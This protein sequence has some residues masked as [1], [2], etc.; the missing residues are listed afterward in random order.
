[1]KGLSGS[2][3]GA[4]ATDLFGSLHLHGSQGDEAHRKM[5]DG[6]LVLDGAEFVVGSLLDFAVAESGEV[7]LDHDAA[8]INV[9][10]GDG[11]AGDTSPSVI[12]DVKIFGAA[13]GP[14]VGVAG[15][16]DGTTVGIVLRECGVDLEGASELEAI[17]LALTPCAGGCHLESGVADGTTVGSED[18]GF[19][20]IAGVNG[21]KGAALHL[22]DDE[23]VEV[24]HIIGG[25]A[26][27]DGSSFELVDALEF[28]DEGFGDVG[29]GSVVGECGF[30]EGDSFSRDDDVCSISADE[31]EVF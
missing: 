14:A 11:V 18:F 24:T 29:I 6:H 1:M 8:S 10:E 2:G 21:D 25:V 28:L 15:M 26:E 20:G 7:L 13:I 17:P 23:V 16:A 30:D 19:L 4:V 9:L 3:K 5:G 22:M 27:K 12:G 31:E